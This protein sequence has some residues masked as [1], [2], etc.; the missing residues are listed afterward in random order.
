M[1]ITDQ[2]DPKKECQAVNS[3]LKECVEPNTHCL[4]SVQYFTMVINR[5]NFLPN[6]DYSELNDA[7]CGSPFQNK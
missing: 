5:Q 3:D 1:L 2:I 6:D 7:C 4:Y